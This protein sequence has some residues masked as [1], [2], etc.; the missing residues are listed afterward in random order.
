MTDTR[1]TRRA[2]LIAALAPAA[3]ALAPE[4]LA[5][6]VR[7]AAREGKP[8]LR[9]ATLRRVI[10]TPEDEA[11]LE[12]LGAIRSGLRRFLNDRFALTPEQRDEIA[13][14][15]RRDIAAL[16]RLLDDAIEARAQIMVTIRQVDTQ[17]STGDTDPPE[18]PESPGTPET[19]APEG[20]VPEDPRD[21]DGEPPKRREAESSGFFKK[22]VGVRMPGQS[23]A[24]RIP[25]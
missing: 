21:P 24:L 2:C 20:P 6:T 17:A 22:L 18:T 8:M 5:E 15:P 16:N 23:V 19:P 4:A 14:I 1:L 13:S 12:T 3:A 10:G 11:Y 25:G 7:L 9:Q